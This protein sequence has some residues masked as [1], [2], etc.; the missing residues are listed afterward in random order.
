MPP[1]W[2]PSPQSLPS[3][4][5][6]QRSYK[7]QAT[8]Y[9]Y[10]QQ[11]TSNTSNKQQATSNKQQATGNRQQATTCLFLLRGEE[12][13]SLPTRGDR[14]SAPRVDALALGKSGL[15]SWVLL[16]ARRP[17]G[18]AWPWA[19]QVA[20]QRRVVRGGGGTLHTGAW[21]AHPNLI[22]DA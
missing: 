14:G 17:E 13:G 2:C 10:K 7:L 22:M 3:L 18:C 4:Q 11:A 12:K 19:S 1:T 15:H 6:R 21:S 20:A 8:D 5:P 16:G 9:R